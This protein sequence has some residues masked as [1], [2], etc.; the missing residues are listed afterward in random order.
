M[1]QDTCS[2]VEGTLYVKTSFHNSGT[3]D[4]DPTVEY[5]ALN[6]AMMKIWTSSS[7]FLTPCLSFIADNSNILGTIS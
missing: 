7:L 2:T 5:T 4:L 6:H 1:C 3:S